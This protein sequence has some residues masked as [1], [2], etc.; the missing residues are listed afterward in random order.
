[1]R[2]RRRGATEKPMKLHAINFG[3]ADWKRLDSFEDRTVFQTRAWVQFVEEAQGATPVLAELRE[4]ADVVGY[5]TGL[6][7]SKFGM[8]VLGSSFPGW[9]TPYM[10][11]NLKQGVPR[12]AALEAL[13]KFAWDELKCLHIEVSDPEFTVEDGEVLGFKAE[14]YA[15][16]RTDLS[17]SEEELFNAMESA[18]RRCIRKAEKSGVTIEE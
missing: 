11:F 2:P 4:G 18:C 1:M 3:A 9:T 15:S 12:R 8:K 16:Y 13:E 6:T 7:F 10:G 14:Y 17:K 5:F